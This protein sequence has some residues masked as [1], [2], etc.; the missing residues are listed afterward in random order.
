MAQGQLQPGGA[1]IDPQAP[2]RLAPGQML[3]SIT[4]LEDT[5]EYNLPGGVVAEVAVYTHH[6]HHLALLRNVLLRMSS[7]M[8]YVFL[9]H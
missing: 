5:S 9:E 7:W 1:L 3:A 6:M 8:N 2:E 4:I